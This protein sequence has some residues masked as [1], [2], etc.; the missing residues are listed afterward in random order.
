MPKLREEFISYSIPQCPYCGSYNINSPEFRY[1]AC[2]VCML[3]FSCGNCQ[4]EWQE[5]YEKCRIY[6]N[7]WDVNYLDEV[8]IDPRT[9][10]PSQLAD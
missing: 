8:V 5:M 4:E 6:G 7:W 10:A 2:E 9:E 1:L 3:D